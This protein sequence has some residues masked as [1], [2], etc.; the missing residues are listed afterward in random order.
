[1]I[2]NAAHGLSCLG[3]YGNPTPLPGHGAWRH[4]HVAGRSQR[5]RAHE[6]GAGQGALLLGRTDAVL[7]G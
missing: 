6:R 4:G 2:D 5:L 7:G 3:H 1:M